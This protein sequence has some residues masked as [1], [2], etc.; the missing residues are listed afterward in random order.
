MKTIQKLK[1][2][3]LT[4]DELSKLKGVLSNLESACIPTLIKIKLITVFL[5][6]C[7]NNKTSPLVVVVNKDK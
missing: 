3:Q 5:R 2:L 7:G 6:S 1:K 4:S